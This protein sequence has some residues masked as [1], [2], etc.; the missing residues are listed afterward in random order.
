MNLMIMGI[1][2]NNPN[3]NAVWSVIFMLVL[4]ALVLYSIYKD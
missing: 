3:N 2:N 1:F 4:L